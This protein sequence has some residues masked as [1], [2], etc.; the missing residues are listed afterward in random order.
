MIEIDG[1]TRR[2]GEDMA[3]D[4]LT[5]TIGEGEVFGLLG[6]NGAGASLG[7]IAGVLAAVD[8]ALAIASLATFRREEILTRWA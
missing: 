3:V 8:G 7:V 5:L 2:F 4:G 1:L 6:P